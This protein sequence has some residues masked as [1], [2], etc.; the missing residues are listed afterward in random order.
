MSLRNRLKIRSVEEWVP[1]TSIRA[2]YSSISKKFSNPKGPP[3]FPFKNWSQNEQK[4]QRK[5]NLKFQIHRWHKKSIQS[6]IWLSAPSTHFD[7]MNKKREKIRQRNEFKKKI[8]RLVT[9]LNLAV[10]TNYP[11]IHSLGWF[12]TWV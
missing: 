11:R 10:K 2:I 4:S 1:Y 9:A 5:S 8:F 12:E 6:F 7:R 3:K